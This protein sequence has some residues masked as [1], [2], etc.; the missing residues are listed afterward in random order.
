MT[1][2][3]LAAMH[4]DTEILEVLLEA[5]A[6][7]DLQDKVC[8]LPVYLERSTC[9]HIAAAF[10]SYRPGERLSCGHPRRVTLR[11]LFAC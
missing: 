2:L 7:I 4:G 10:V 11:P 9:P 8:S 6:A 1:A 3:M 5:E